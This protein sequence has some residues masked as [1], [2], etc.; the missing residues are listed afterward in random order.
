MGVFF[1]PPLFFYQ[2]M[3]KDIKMEQSKKRKLLFYFE[4]N[5]KPIILTDETTEN[6]SQEAINF[7]KML[8]KPN[9]VCRISTPY[10]CL[11]VKSSDI[12]AILISNLNDN[13][14]DYDTSKKEEKKYPEWIQNN[15][16][17]KNILK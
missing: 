5:P 16:I 7:A 14:L 10:D 13:K 9:L 6:V 4:N 15:W 8:E 2:E 11:I 17:K 12:K 3:E 1:I